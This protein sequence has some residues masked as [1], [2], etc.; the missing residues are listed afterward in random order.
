M[1]ESLGD[2]RYD[3][4]NWVQDQ[5]GLLRPIAEEVVISSIKNGKMLVTENGVF[6]TETADEFEG[7]VKKTAH[8]ISKKYA[9]THFRN[10]NKGKK[11][12]NKSTDSNNSAVN[13]ANDMLNN[14]IDDGDDN[15]IS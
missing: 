3:A 5:F 10:H 1:L 4:I 2:D 8:T 6:L 12:F 11:L 7:T 13:A 14:S 15:A 9:R